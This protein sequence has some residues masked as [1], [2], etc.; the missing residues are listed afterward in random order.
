MDPGDHPYTPDP[1]GVRLAV[2]LTP[3]AR[4]DALDGVVE[5]PDGRKALHLRV[6]APP[7]EGA[8]N[9]A[10]VGFVAKSLGL[11]RADVTLRAGQTS[12]LK[13]LHLA[14][15]GAAIIDRLERWLSARGAP[16]PGRTAPHPSI[17]KRC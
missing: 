8:A 6:A 16:E 12:R 15:D 1:H 2:R 10:L 11:R 3:N 9:A 13:L 17:P 14:G 7:V 4:R 5:G